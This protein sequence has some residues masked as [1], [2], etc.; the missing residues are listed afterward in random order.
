ME[1]I[2]ER[3]D[4]HSHAQ[5]QFVPTSSE[6]QEKSWCL[7]FPKLTTRIEVLQRNLR[8]CLGEDL[9]PLNLRELQNIEQQIDVGLKR[10][11]TRKNQ[12][13]NET[14]SEMQKKAKALQEE[15]NL[16]SKKLKENENTLADQSTNWDQQVNITSPNTST[17]V[18]LAPP[19]R[20][21][22]LPS[23][24]IGGTFQGKEMTEEDSGTQAQPTTNTSIP[25]WM[26]RHLNR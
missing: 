11:R 3:Y 22:S 7:E 4:R 19:P 5:R 15:N 13:M 9:D 18:L 8:N 12:L 21:R 17:L 25:P 26:L 2:L 1:T 20:T 16:I 14:I 6:S 10:V 23:L 24:T